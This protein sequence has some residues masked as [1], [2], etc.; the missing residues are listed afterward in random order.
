M[1]GWEPT[2]CPGTRNPHLS[3][4][5]VTHSLNPSSLSSYIKITTKSFQS[6]L[7]NLHTISNIT[8]VFALTNFRMT[9]AQ[10]KVES[11]V[12][13]TFPTIIF[14]AEKVV[15]LKLILTI[16]YLQCEFTQPFLISCSDCAMSIWWNKLT[17]LRI[18][19]VWWGGGATLN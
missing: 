8:R 19:A 4:T 2:V 16:F 11:R 18:Q 10:R 9:I 6:E 12:T 17:G 14:A 5:S 15:I 1:Q 13:K 3:A 7:N